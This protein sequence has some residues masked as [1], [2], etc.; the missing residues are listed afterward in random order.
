MTGRDRRPRVP[1]IAAA[2]ALAVVTACGTMG[3]GLPDNAVAVASPLSLEGPPIYSLLGFRSD[4]NL[5]SE[6]ITA[7]D[8]IALA[9][10]DENR[11][12]IAELR[13]VDGGRDA[14]GG[15]FVVTEHGRPIFETIRANHMNAVGAVRELL[16]ET[17]RE[18]VCEIVAR[19]GQQRAQSGRGPRQQSDQGTRPA[20]ADSVDERTRLSRPVT[21]DWCPAPGEQRETR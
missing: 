6:Q 17:Q 16:D 1:I 12:L 15:T 2:L 10:R 8:S 13:A 9:V 7:L 11:E 14:V 20:S 19:P 18:E 4:L 21:W 5:T 3:G